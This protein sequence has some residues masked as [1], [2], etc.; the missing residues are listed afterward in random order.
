MSEKVKISIILADIPAY[1]ETFI[2]SKIKGLINNRKQVSLFVDK[3]SR[4]LNLQ[5]NVPVYIQ[6]DINKKAG[7]II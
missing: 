5:M 2:R 3:S 7:D 6:L 4:E 1:S